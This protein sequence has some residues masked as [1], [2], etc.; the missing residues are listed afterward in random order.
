M[1]PFW[2]C[3]HL[4]RLPRILVGVRG[5][6]HGNSCLSSQFQHVEPEKDGKN[7]FKQD[8]RAVGNPGVGLVLFILWL[9][10][11]ERE[12]EREQQPSHA[13]VPLWN[14]HSKSCLKR[15]VQ[16]FVEYQEARIPVKDVLQAHSL[17][18]CTESIMRAVRMRRRHHGLLPGASGFVWVRRLPRLPRNILASRVLNCEDPMSQHYCLAMGAGFLV[19]CSS[20]WEW[21]RQM[22]SEISLFN[23]FWQI[24]NTLTNNEN[25]G[26]RCK[27]STKTFGPNVCVIA[28]EFPDLHC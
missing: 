9:Q 21:C 1:K 16:I 19:L 5:L 12:L 28:S 11:E 7:V 14:L 2:S 23:W 10:G 20:C 25:A 22:R 13:K 6:M 8:F 3:A 15:R 26:N 18:S 27:K 24:L 17:I 4:N